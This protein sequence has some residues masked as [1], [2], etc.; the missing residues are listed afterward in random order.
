[1][2]II[3]VRRGFACLV[4]LCALAVS[5]VAAQSQ[6]FDVSGTWAFDVQTGAGGGTPTIVFK[7]DGEKLT[8]H[9]T[10]TFGEADLTGSVKGAE[11]QFSFSADMQGMALTS[12]YKGTIESNTAMK[13][14]LSISQVG[15][16]TFTAKKK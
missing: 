13:G 10:G 1:M 9:Y 2:T 16:G 6:K 14:T 8:G 5:V 4:V 7:Q 11:I 12:A 15:D 3:A